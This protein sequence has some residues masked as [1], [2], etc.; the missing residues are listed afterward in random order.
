MGIIGV[1]IRALFYCF[2]LRRTGSLWLGI[3]FH[4]AWD[5]AQSWLPP[6]GLG[7]FAFFWALKRAGLIVAAPQASRLLAPARKLTNF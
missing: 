4:A 7:M 1:T 6:F 5:W 3:G 2:F